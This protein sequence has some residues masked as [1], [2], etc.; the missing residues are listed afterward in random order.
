MAEKRGGT[1]SIVPVKRGS[2]GSNRGR[3]GPAF[4]GR[5]DPAFGVVGVALLAP[6][7]GEAI[8][9]AA[10]DHERHG[11]GRFAER[12][13]QAARSQRIERA[14]VAGAFCR[15]QALDD[16]DRV[17]R[18]HADRLVEHDPAMHVAFLPFLVCALSA[19]SRLRSG[20]TV[21]PCARGLATSGADCVPSS[22]AAGDGMIRRGHQSSFSPLKVALDHGCSQKL[23]D[24]FR[25][26][27]S[28][29]D[30][31]ANLRSKFQVNAPRDLAAHISL[32]ALERVEHVLAR[33]G[34][35]AA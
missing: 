25:F 30:A 21:R 35:R 7:H 29:V 12:D 26:V 14:G 23:L 33:R 6:A 15:E 24:P 2:S 9:F 1:C 17:G 8:G 27:E 18:G 20:V 5:H 11:L 28:F 10:V 3:V 4:A 34:R 19:R 32:V 31:E 22:A 16:R 13:R